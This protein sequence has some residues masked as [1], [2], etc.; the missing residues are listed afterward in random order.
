MFSKFI[1]LRLH[2][3]K[4]YEISFHGWKV[5]QPHTFS[6]WGVRGPPR[7]FAP[8]A[9]IFFWKGMFRDFSFTNFCISRRF[10]R[11]SRALRARTRTRTRRI[12]LL[13]RKVWKHTCK[14]KID[15]QKTILKHVNTYKNALCLNVRGA[16]DFPKGAEARFPSVFCDFVGN[17]PNSAT[18]IS[19][20]STGVGFSKIK[21]A[22]YDK[23]AL[24]GS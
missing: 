2:T 5:A 21:E 22:L 19:V 8:Q 12:A 7:V 1:E 20:E 23:N 6:C 14:S 9:E 17:Y 15:L 18:I 3:L 11:S 10:P 24:H 4:I 16:V 13:P